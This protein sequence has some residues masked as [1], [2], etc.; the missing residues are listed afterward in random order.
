MKGCQL[1]DQLA[2]NV[3]YMQD[4]GK[5]KNY[6]NGNGCNDYNHSNFCFDRV[7]GTAP[8]HLEAEKQKKECRR[9]DAAWSRP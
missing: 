6:A 5:D 1:R 2:T 3:H 8:V 7:L 4:W 9:R